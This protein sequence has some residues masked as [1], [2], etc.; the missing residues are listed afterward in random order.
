L[1]EFVQHENYKGI[2]IRSIPFAV[3]S[4]Q[5]QKQ[6]IVRLDITFTTGNASSS[7]PEYLNAR[8]VYLTSTDAHL[9][10]LE[11]GR[12]IVDL[13]QDSGQ[14]PPPEVMDG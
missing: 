9:A 8:L 4:R 12:R 7:T 13:W 10:G 3:F 6:W 2:S 1:G 14:I 11:W 5:G